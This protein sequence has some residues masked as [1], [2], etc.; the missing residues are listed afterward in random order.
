[1]IDINTAS[2]SEKMEQIEK[3]FQETILSLKALH[4]EKLNLIKR[5]R[6]EGNLLELNKIRESLKG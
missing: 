1:M 2:E 5:F 6:Q 3:I 4:E